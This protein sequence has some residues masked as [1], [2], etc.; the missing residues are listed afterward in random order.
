MLLTLPASI[1]IADIFHLSDGNKIEGTIIR[2]IGDL[3]SIRDQDGQIITIDRSQITRV[4]KKSTAL[5]EYLKRSQKIKSEDLE[6][7]RALAIWCQQKQLISQAQKHWKLVI[8]IDPDHDEARSNLGYVWI[9]GDWYIKGSPEATKRREELTADP[10]VPVREI[11]EELRLPDWDREDLPDLPELP[12][13]GSGKG[14][15]VV[16][17]ADEKVGRSKPERSGLIYH[18]RRMGGK[19]QFVPGSEKDAKVVVKV[20]TRCYFVRLQTF[21]GAPIANI[22]QGEA[23][24]QFFERNS[25]GKMVLRKTTTVRIP[26]S[27]S[28]QRPREQALHYTYYATLE[29]IAARISRWGWM[30]ERG[31]R[32]LPIPDTK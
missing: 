14:D 3:V 7:H 1:C 25:S 8:S 9:G 20:R 15:V 11:P 12:P 21:Y 32:S 16:V 19:I 22:F 2:E 29:S 31:S 5:D 6:A 23:K 4:E 17:V 10:D 27:S 30:K 28:A 18:L 13:V 26:F 24:A